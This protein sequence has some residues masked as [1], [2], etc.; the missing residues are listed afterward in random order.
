MQDDS[1]VDVTKI[2]YLVPEFPAQ[3]HIF[4][5]REISALRELGAEVQI[6]STRPGD[7]SQVKHAFAKPGKEQCH[8]TFP[9]SVKACVYLL[10]K[11]AW[12]FKAMGYA[13]SLKANLKEKVR[14]LA[15]IPSAAEILIHAESKGISHVHGHSC[16]NVGHVLAMAALSG[17][18]SFSLT[19]HGDLVAYG[20]CHKEKMAPAAFVSAVTRPLQQQIH[21]QVGLPV[22]DIPVIWMGV[23]LNKFKLKQYP[24]DTSAPLRFISVTRLDPGKG[25]CFALEALAKAKAEG[26]AFHYDIIGGGWYEDEIR[27]TISKLGL[28]NEVTIR[29]SLSEDDVL[30]LLEGADVLLLTSAALFEAAPVCVMEAMAIG[31]PAICS[32]IGGTP[33]MIVDGVDGFL[34]EQKNVDQIFDSIKR[35]AEDRSLCESMGKAARKSAEAK[36]SHITQAQNLLNEITKVRPET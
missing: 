9:P 2:G 18:M 30:S 35:F 4:F 31:V 27:S 17:R 3:T 28:D 6:L 26:I 11:P 7:L 24:S 22:Q 23:D 12:L 20:T 1:A 33:D 36:F 16:A 25:H 5:W 32:I 10:K 19:L 21:Q 8:Y 15:M 29:G 14:T 34:T 13:L